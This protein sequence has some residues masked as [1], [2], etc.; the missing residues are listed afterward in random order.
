MDMAQ[1]DV[2]NCGCLCRHR[3]GRTDIRKDSLTERAGM[4]DSSCI[5]QAMDAY[6]DTVWRCCLA[7]LRNRADAQD[8]FQDT[9]LAY[10]THDE[11]VFKDPE[12]EKA[13]LLRVAINTCIDLL[14]SPAS[15]V[16][17]LDP[18][19]DTL[20]TSEP[21]D[22]PDEALWEVRQALGTLPGDQCQAIYLTVCEGYPATDVAEMM[23]VSVNTVYSWISRG[24]KKLREALA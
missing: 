1:E 22:N 11:Y 5:E 15:R 20:A 7:R 14:R 10:A 21:S 6:G 12:H 19:Y 13:W 3:T 17:Q 4:R 9:F 23:G 24:K 8:A 18:D 2:L 16:A